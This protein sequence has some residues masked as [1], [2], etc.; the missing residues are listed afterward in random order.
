MSYDYSQRTE[1]TP[2]GMDISQERMAEERQEAKSET[3]RTTTEG[4]MK[5]TMR[6]SPE[7]EQQ[8]AGPQYATVEEGPE[9]TA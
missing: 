9:E 6:E 3:R 7:Y 2:R 1:S 5:S 4:G 8:K